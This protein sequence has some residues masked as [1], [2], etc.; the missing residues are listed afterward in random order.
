MASLIKNISPNA[1]VGKGNRGVGF[2]VYT[3][4]QDLLHKAPALVL[5]SANERL[6][7]YE[8]T[9]DTAFKTE[10]SSND[11]TNQQFFTT[12]YNLDS[13]EYLLGFLTDKPL[14]SVT[15]ETTNS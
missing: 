13:V 4:W 2:P 5:D 8:P 9:N 3:R 7:I 15:V 10:K 6:V 1:V 14:V 11:Y 12:P